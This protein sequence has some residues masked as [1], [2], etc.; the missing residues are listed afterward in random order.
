MKLTQILEQVRVGDTFYRESKP[1]ILYE[2]I[3]SLIERGGLG[4]A[5]LEGIQQYYEWRII[6]EQRIDEDVHAMDWTI[7][8]GNLKEYRPSA[9]KARMR[10]NFSEKTRHGWTYYDQIEMPKLP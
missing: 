2:R 8:K 10:P 9:K 7:R 4:W 3:G 6:P 5:R 1:E